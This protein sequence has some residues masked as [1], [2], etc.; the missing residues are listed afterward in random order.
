MPNR[1]VRNQIIENEQKRKIDYYILEGRK[2]V[3]YKEKILEDFKLTQNQKSSV[4]NQLEIIKAVGQEIK[5]LEILPN[6]TLYD[7]LK[8]KN[9]GKSDI[10]VSKIEIDQGYNPYLFHINRVIS[11][12]KIKSNDT[13]LFILE[14]AAQPNFQ[15]KGNSLPFEYRK[16]KLEIEFNKSEKMHF[17]FEY[18][19]LNGQ[20]IDISMLD[21]KFRYDDRIIEETILFVP[22]NGVSYSLTTENNAISYYGKFIKEND[23]MK[24]VGDWYFTHPRNYVQYSVELEFQITTNKSLIDSALEVFAIKQGQRLNLKYHFFNQWFS[25]WLPSKIDSVYFVWKNYHNTVSGISQNH[26]QTKYLVDL[27]PQ[28]VETIFPRKYNQFV[29]NTPYEFVPNVYLLKLKSEDNKNLDK[30]RDAFMVAYR[31][32]KFQVDARY[33]KQ[34]L[35]VDF[36]GYSYSDKMKW[37]WKWIYRKEIEYAHIGMHVANSG[38]TFLGNGLTIKPQQN[39]YGDN[40]VKLVR[41]YG[42]ELNHSFGDGSYQLVSKSAICNEN[43]FENMLRVVHDKQ[44]V[45]ASPN[46]FNP[47]QPTLD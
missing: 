20:Q 3:F 15:F 1:I 47:L 24:R 13:G 29:V 21:E 4:I 16:V 5:R 18:L 32:I 19:G 14:I 42:F 38:V 26:Y 41:E 10:V 7:T 46:F 17:K 8:I 23:T 39:L 25:V 31:G 43:L 12:D 35:L 36:E 30:I 27:F 11:P 2:W 37:L 9:K 33:S 40:L 34:Y 45:L 28:T 44:F 22:H 6:L